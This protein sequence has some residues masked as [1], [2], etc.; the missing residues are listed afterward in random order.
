MLWGGSPYKIRWI[1]RQPVVRRDCLTTHSVFLRNH[2]HVQSG[3]QPCT[4][5]GQ[6]AVSVE[7][8]CVQQTPRFR[9][10]CMK[11]HLNARSAVHEEFRRCRSAE[12]WTRPKSL[13]ELQNTC[14]VLTVSIGS[15]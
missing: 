11:S 2:L 5:A 3:T 8:S 9:R 1:E 12:Q 13:R 14:S 6:R 15:G 10:C 4:E 7:T